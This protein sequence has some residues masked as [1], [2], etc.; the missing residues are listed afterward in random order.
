MALILILSWKQYIYTHGLKNSLIITQ[1][2]VAI[3][4]QNLKKQTQ[5]Y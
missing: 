4:L 5:Y 2:Y 1:T 3:V